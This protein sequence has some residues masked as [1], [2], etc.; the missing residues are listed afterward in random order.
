MF[1][2]DPGRLHEVVAQRPV[3]VHDFHGTAAEHVGR[4]HEHRVADAL[5]DGD[6]FLDRARDA[7]GRLRDAQPARE[8]LEALAIFGDVDRVRRGAEDR[9]ARGLERLGELQRR[10]AAE[11]DDDALGLL[12]ADDL[13]HVFERQRLEVQLVRNVE[14]SR[15]GLGVRVDHD[16]L[17]PELA[18]GESGADTA[19]VEFDALPDAVGTAAQDHDAL[20]AERL[21]LVFL[22]IRGIEIR[23]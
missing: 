10:L 23:R 11:L 2:G 3:V 8:L 13:D 16:R 5:R 15:D 21:R 19:I 20:L 1:R 7:V 14:V 12:P 9:H 6:G 18:K 22:V 4:A 17:E